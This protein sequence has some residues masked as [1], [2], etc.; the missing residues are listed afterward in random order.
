MG[1]YTNYFISINGYDGEEK[2]E[3]FVARQLEYGNPFENECK[4]YDHE[5]DM[6]NLSR[7]YPELV[8]HLCGEG[9]ESGDIW[10]KH[11][12]NGK[13]QVCRAKIKY[14]EYDESKLV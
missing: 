9:E 10:K 4:W 13:M 12:K 1:Y 6:K 7:K 14:D 2:P 3:K 8:F 5:K 11:F